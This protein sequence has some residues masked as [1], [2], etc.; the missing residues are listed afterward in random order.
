MLVVSFFSV[1]VYPLTYF[2]IYACEVCRECGWEGQKAQGSVFVS[3]SG[4][5][6][7]GDQVVLTHYERPRHTIS[8][9]SHT[10]Q[11]ITQSVEVSLRP[12]HSLADWHGLK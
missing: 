11:V 2:T 3:V 10:L 5:G 1:C 12:S 6:G 4:V 8:C 7:M 9:L